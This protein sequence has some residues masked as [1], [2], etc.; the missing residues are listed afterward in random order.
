MVVIYSENS[1]KKF[2]IVDIGVKFKFFVYLIDFYGN[3]Y[4]M[5]NLRL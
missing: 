1:I 3:Y 5:Y 2:F 4:N